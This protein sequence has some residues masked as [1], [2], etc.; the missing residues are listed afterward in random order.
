MAAQVKTLEVTPGDPEHL[1][2]I[3]ASNPV[4]SPFNMHPVQVDDPPFSFPD[5][6]IPAPRPI[7]D[8]SSKSRSQRTVVRVLGPL[9]APVL[10]DSEQVSSNLSL[11]SLICTMKC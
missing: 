11:S 3:P 5:N 10:C 6:P 7:V 1:S 9:T 8:Y 2:P 4:A